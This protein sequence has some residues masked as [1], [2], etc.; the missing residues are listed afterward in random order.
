VSGEKQVREQMGNF[1]GMKGC[2]RDKNVK[3]EECEK[4]R[5][6]GNVARGV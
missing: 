3:G 4:S 1:E 2:E 5:S 6:Q